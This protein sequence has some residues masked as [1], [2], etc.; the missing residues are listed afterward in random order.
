MEPS[1]RTHCLSIRNSL[2]TAL[3]LALQSFAAEE[4]TP[5][6]N[7]II[8][9]ADDLG[10]HDLGCYGSEIIATPNL[11]QLAAE[12]RRFTSFMVASSVCTPSRAALLTGCYPKRIGLHRRVL[13]P[14]SQIGLNPAELTLADHLKARGYATA[15]IGK[16]HLG[17]F[18]ET[19]PRKHG[20]DTYFGIPYSNDMKHPDNKGKPSMSYGAQWKN[21]ETVWKTWNT[22]L[23]ENEQIVELPV[24]QRTVTRRYTD[25]AIRFVTEHK[26]HPFFLYLAHTM[27]HV[28]LFVPDEAR[29]PNPKNAYRCTVEHLDAEIGRLMDAVRR[30]GL[31]RRT[32]LLFTSDNGP[33]LKEP[34]G[35][36]LPL[37][38]GKA[39][40]FEGGHRMPCILWAPG[41]VAAHTTSDAL[42]SSL[43][44][45]PTF[46]SLTG[47]PLTV[48]PVIDGLDL[49]AMV[50][51]DG[52]ERRQE[53]LYYSAQGHLAGIRQGSYKL[54]IRQGD[55][56]E[57]L[58]KQPPLLFDLAKDISESR[59]LAG[60]MPEKVESLRKRMDELDAAVTKGA[61]PAWKA[62]GP[63]PWPAKPAK[64]TS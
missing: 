7:V 64:Q 11:D 19:L 5:Q 45:L 46:A 21:S 28:P 57:T 32:I 14:Q 60:H 37:R 61:R 29:D 1:P 12:G 26:D 58:T 16:W 43:D 23:V 25:R 62:G 63:H 2:F 8:I 59:N 51:G 55:G 36:A 18:P 52:P 34:G 42:W 13:V 6:P 10:Y 9:L 41:R 35:S 17:H 47:N 49:T 22:P 39:T 3:A 20:F 27:P 31:E 30:I 56:Q 40:P 38:G 24:D 48:G 33:R 54:L 4:I 44:V 15:C 50:M 53:F